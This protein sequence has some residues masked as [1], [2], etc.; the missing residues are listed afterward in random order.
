[1]LITHQV[2]EANLHEAIARL[3][4]LSCVDCVASRIRVNGD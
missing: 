3:N 1:V 4:K 2:K